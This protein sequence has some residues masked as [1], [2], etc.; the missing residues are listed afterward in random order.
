MKINDFIKSLRTLN[1]TKQQK[2]TL[3]GQALSGDLKGAKK[4]LAKLIGAD[5]ERI[6]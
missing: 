2:K 1:L 3:R 4:G 6:N 5:N